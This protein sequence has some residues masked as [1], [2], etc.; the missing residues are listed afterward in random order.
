M[1]T[2]TCFLKTENGPAGPLNNGKFGPGSLLFTLSFGDNLKCP[3][4][5]R[6]LTSKLL[7]D[8][9]ADVCLD[10]RWDPGGGERVSP[11]TKD[12]ALSFP[13]DDCD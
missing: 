4:I 9:K 6:S 12:L 5:Y 2:Y 10:L 7:W 1:G 8:E 11:D 13:S 3:P